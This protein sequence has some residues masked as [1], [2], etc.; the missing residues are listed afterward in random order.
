MRGVNPDKIPYFVKKDAELI[1]KEAVLVL[2][3]KKNGDIEIVNEG[4]RK[5]INVIAVLGPAEEYAI[6]DCVL[7]RF[8]FDEALLCEIGLRRNKPYNETQNRKREKEERKNF[9]KRRKWFQLSKNQF[10]KVA[11]VIFQILQG[12]TDKRV[13]GW[14]CGPRN[15]FW[16][17]TKRYKVVKGGKIL[18]SYS[19]S[20][21][22]NCGIRFSISPKDYYFLSAVYWAE[23]NNPAL[24]K[25]LGG[26]ARFIDK[27]LS[28]YRNNGF[29]KDFRKLKGFQDVKKV[30]SK[31]SPYLIR[32]MLEEYL[33]GKENNIFY[34]YL[35][36]I[37]EVDNCKY[38]EKILVETASSLFDAKK[39]LN[40][41]S[42]KITNGNK[43]NGKPIVFE[44]FSQNSNIGS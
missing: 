37:F 25:Y 24:G 42:L 44:V 12:I 4:S 2:R 36:Q 11:P 21:K 31:I 16:V 23:F 15:P 3:I 22:C 30:V 20:V 5:R 7:R 9:T 33:P 17:K 29:R 41:I 19:K 27:R 8:N 10:V 43:G 32:K 28:H 38:K 6:S 26:L 13:D 34:N 14:K 39:I 35:M 1:K 40:G 18:K